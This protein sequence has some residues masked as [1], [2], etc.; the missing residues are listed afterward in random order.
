MDYETMDSSGAVVVLNGARP[1][2]P[3]LAVRT[4]TVYLTDHYDG[5]EATMRLNPRRAVLDELRSGDTRRCTDAMAQIVTQW[6]F[7]DEAGVAIPLT[8]DEMYNLPDDLLAAVITGY[9]EEF[10]RVVDVPKR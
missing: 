8:P 6:N 4:C 9:L 7:C 10:N 5:F 1:A 2:G 3:R